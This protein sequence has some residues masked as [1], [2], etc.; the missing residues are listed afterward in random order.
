MLSLYKIK[1]D[2]MFAHV[3]QGDYC[4]ALIGLICDSVSLSHSTSEVEVDNS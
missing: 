4:K 3:V 2:N 1:Q